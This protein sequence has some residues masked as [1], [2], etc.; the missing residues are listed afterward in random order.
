[1]C[2]ADGTPGEEG[3]ETREGKQ[4]IEDN[5]TTCAQ[6]DVA[7]G[8]EDQDGNGRVK[9]STGAINV[10]EPMWRVPLLGEGS[11]SSRASVDA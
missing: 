6:G 11:Q 2:Q 1:M 9:G 5:G 4:P 3:R 10:G 7:Q 8:A